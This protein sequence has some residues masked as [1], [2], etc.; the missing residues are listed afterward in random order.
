[1]LIVFIIGTAGSGKSLL[2]AS[3]NE[4]LK[5]GKQKTATVNLDP[6][7]LTLPYV[8]DVDV[9]NYINVN[10]LME[11]YGLGPNGALLMAADL[12]AEEAQRLGSEIQDL[13]SDV[14]VVDTPGQMELF[15]FRASGP[16]I[17]NELTK[18]PKAIIYLFDAVFSFNPL[19]YVSNMFLSA[20]VYN[21]FFVPQLHVLSKCDLLPPEEANRIVDWSANPKALE[22]VIEEELSGTRRLLSRDMMHV[23]CRLG[24]RFLLIPVSAKT[25]DG[26][27][28]LN[29]ALERIFAGGEKFTF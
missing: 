29:T 16:Y 5:I 6:G 4:W 18:E 9:R 28:N 8:P 22:A 27:I 15:A 2:T 1:M 21:R 19:N 26:L 12:I 24:L 10:E 14:V 13:K 23:I 3:L 17:V 25:N 11:K 20:A 7:V